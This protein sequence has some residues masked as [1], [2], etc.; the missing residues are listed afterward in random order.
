M[1]TTRFAHGIWRR[2]KHAARKGPVRATLLL[3]TL[4]AMLV[5]GGKS[6]VPAA[7]ETTAS[8]VSCDTA[9]G[10]FT[11]S[12]TQVL[13]AGSRVFVSYGITIPG[14]VGGN[15]QAAINIDPPKIKAAADYWC[16]NTVRLQV[17]QDNLLGP[18]G[19]RPNPAYMAA[20]ES[21][22]SLA[23]SYHLVV[24]LNDSTESAPTAT[25]SYQQG[26]TRGTETFWK[27]MAV[28]YGHDPQV[29]FDLFNEP[30]TYSSGMSEAEKWRLWR[31]G[32]G[33]GTF[34][35]HHY[36]GM[37][38]LAMYVRTTVGATNLFW[39]EGPDYSNTFGGMETQNA[40]ITGVSG[41]VYAIH[42]PAGPH[43]VL[44]WYRDF[45][46]LIDTGAAPVVDG[47]WT[48]YAPKAEFGLLPT[49]PVPA[50]SECWQDA[51]SQV[52]EYLQYLYSHGVGMSAYQ[53]MSDLLVQTR[54]PNYDDP[55]TIDP[56]TWTCHPPNEL[57][58]YRQLDQGAGALIMSWFKL[59]N[60]S[61]GSP[62]SG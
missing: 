36:L 24:V 48:N 14:L 11:V 49:I 57:Y 45:G 22:V 37:E 39:I 9:T 42:H 50:N 16:A 47:E 12:G 40:L 38:N 33:T 15:W 32:T 43:D 58:G 20:I 35:G 56:D 51:P 21:E 25:Q 28:I 34:N 5:V 53:L 54:N 4:I 3:A 41:V 18:H 61:P 8:S 29:I 59:H 44:N 52:P 23:E 27:D 13:G 1:T 30:R 7:A 10:P 17:S 55:T 6:P 60:T 46:Y 62:Y 26:P 2:G 31:N 19:N